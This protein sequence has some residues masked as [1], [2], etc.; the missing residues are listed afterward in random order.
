[1]NEFCVFIPYMHVGNCSMSQS[2][3]DECAFHEDFK[4]LLVSVS[5]TILL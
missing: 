5:C 2:L 3:S 4:E 1:M